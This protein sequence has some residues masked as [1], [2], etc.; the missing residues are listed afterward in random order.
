MTVLAL[1]ICGSLQA[2]STNAAAL[3]VIRRTL[4]SD[5]VRAVGAVDI[6]VS[7][8]GDLSSIPS[9]DARLVDDPPQVVTDF[10][11]AI[12]L[13]DPI[14]IAAP[15]YAG[16]VAGMVKNALDWTV[17]S[18]SFDA[19]TVAVISAGTTGGVNARHDL[20]RTLN[21]HGAHVVAELGIAGPLGKTDAA[22][23]FDD[24]VTIAALERLARSVTDA[25]ALS[26]AQRLE[27]AREIGVHAGLGVDRAA[28]VL[29]AAVE[30]DVLAVN[31]A[32]Y[33]AH[34]RRDLDA[35]R[36]VWDHSDRVV[37]VHPGWPILR[38]WAAVEESWRRI[39]EGPGRNQ[40]I[41]T[42][43]ATTIAGRV[44][45][46]TLDENLIGGAMTGT[47]AATNVFASSPA[48]WKLVAHHGSP[49]IGS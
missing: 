10:R 27:M 26:S 21:W 37:C 45:W 33:D 22:G 38:T 23:R 30:A 34:E 31:A 36:A 8:I 47:V 28:P 39:L 35:M 32:F 15:E 6:E 2:R 19:K 18:G 20:I 29:A 48:G 16:G 49:V 43:V 24:P 4:E 3:A 44:A 13:A 5:D 42:N 46:V 9:F 1:L 17:G 12:E 14:V 7:A 41:V 11:R 40:F 25:L